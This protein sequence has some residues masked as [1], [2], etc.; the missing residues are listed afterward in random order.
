MNLS[1]IHHSIEIVAISMQKSTPPAGDAHHNR[2]LLDR[3]W[4]RRTGSFER[5]KQPER[6]PAQV[7]L[8]IRDRVVRQADA[9]ALLF[10]G[11]V[12]G[13]STNKRSERSAGYS[14]ARARLIHI[15]A[16]H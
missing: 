2:L 8:A 12:S 6:T 14:S 5:G 9:N 16:R 10:L 7:A 3:A 13:C 15:A 11:C 1:S 4:L